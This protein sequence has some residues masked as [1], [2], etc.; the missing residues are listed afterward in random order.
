MPSTRELISDDFRRLN[1]RSVG[2]ALMAGRVA[3]LC[4]EPDSSKTY[5]VGYATGGIWKTDNMGT[6]FKP[7]FDNE[8]TACI[9]AIQVAHA[10]A[11]WKGWEGDDKKLSK[12]A[13]TE[14]GKGQIIWVGT[15]EGNNRN[16]SSWGNGVYRSTNGGE[17]WDHLGLE[18][19]HDIPSMAVDPRDPDVCYV[20]A[21]GHLWGTNKERGVYKTTDG[22]KTWKPVLQIDEKHGCC[23]VHIDPENPDTLY[24][25]MHARLRTSYSFTS[26][27]EKGG[28]FKTTNGGKTWKKL[29]KGLPK[30]TGRIGMDVFDSDSKVLIATIESKEGGTSDIRDDRSKT[31]GVFRSEDG[32][33]SWKRMSVRTPRGWYFGTIYFD[34]KDSQRVYQ[35]GWYTEVSD[36][37]GATFRRGFGDKMH[38]D[39]HA[40]LVNPNDTDHVVNGSDGG[41]YQTLDKGK[42]WVFFNTMAVGQFYNVSF[43]LS[44]PYRLIGGLQDNGTWVGPSSGTLESNDRDDTPKAGTTNADWQHV[45]GGDGFHGEFDPTN[46]DVV[47]AEWQGG[48]ITRINLKTGEKRKVAPAPAEGQP[49]VRFNWNSPFFI[50]PHDPKTIYLVGNHVFKLTQRG[51]KWKQISPDL[52]TNNIDKAVTVGSTAETHCTV[53]T[54]AESE[55]KKGLIWAGSDDGLIHVSENGKDWKNVTPKAVG[56]LYVSRI[57]AS[58]H[59]ASTAYASVD[60]HRSDNM[61]PLILMTKDMGKTWKDITSDLPKGWSVKVV[62]EDRFNPEVIYAGTEQG[63]FVSVNRGGSWVKM[64]GKNLPTV[65]VDDIKQHP[66][67]KDLIIGTHGRSIWVMDDA[68]MVSSLSKKAMSAKLHVFDVVPAKPRYFGEYGGLWTDQIFRALNRPKGAVINYWINTYDEDE[69]SVT[70]KNASGVVVRTLKG[71]AGPGLNRVVWDLEPKEQLKLADKGQEPWMPHF[72]EPGIYSAEIKSGKTK[73]KTEIEVL[74]MDQ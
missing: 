23:E 6:T 2:P 42:N 16:S 48:N 64:H 22:G 7:I 62:R 3:A 44:E 5:Y 13:K 40:L 35:L 41:V 60:G 17:S 70:I 12:K 30:Q 9:G 25:C 33:A 57:D 8:E 53:V 50:S 11:D 71:T 72:V 51:D 49:R 27:S 68:S 73:V 26:G 67:T 18:D 37:G 56:G 21:L 52:T 28:I 20:A 65:P 59:N 38:V 66:L 61:D 31:G 55:L 58:H 47:Y 54:L 63:I 14:K 24:A 32:G 34:P 43:D 19:T 15:G 46:E 29:T 69:V 74:P 4:F 45:L 10:P 36:D 1:W 39:M